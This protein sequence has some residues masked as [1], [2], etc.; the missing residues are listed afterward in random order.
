MLHRL[1]E[2]LHQSVIVVLIELLR[3]AWF[4]CFR[5]TEFAWTNVYEVLL[6]AFSWYLGVSGPETGDFMNESPIA[7]SQ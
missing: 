4:G 2:F 5:L 6:S 3:L 1:S 7:W